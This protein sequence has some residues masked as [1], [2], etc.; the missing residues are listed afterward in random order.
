LKEYYGHCINSLLYVGIHYTHTY[1]I[2]I[3]KKL[4]YVNFCSILKMLSGRGFDKKI[5]YIIYLFFL[6]F[7]EWFFENYWKIRRIVFKVECVHFFVPPKNVVKKSKQLIFS[8]IL[9]IIN[10][11]YIT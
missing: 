2:P 9:L 6:I 8:P 10:R 7:S 3:L 4:F 11:K 1:E 5:D